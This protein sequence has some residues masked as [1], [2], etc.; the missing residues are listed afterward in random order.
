MAM[1]GGLLDKVTG[2]ILSDG[3]EHFCDGRGEQ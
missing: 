3:V 2:T 1:D